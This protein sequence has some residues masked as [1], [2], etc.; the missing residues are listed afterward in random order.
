MNDPISVI[1]RKY[2]ECIKKNQRPTMKKANCSKFNKK[3]GVARTDKRWSGG[4]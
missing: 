3:Q 2:K 1:Y 4:N